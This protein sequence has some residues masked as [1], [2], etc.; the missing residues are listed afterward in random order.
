MLYQREDV[1]A[2]LGLS[3]RM[4]NRNRHPAVAEVH[5]GG[6]TLRWSDKSPMHLT[7][8]WLRDNCA[9]E[10]CRHPGNGQKLYEIVDLP[11]D[12]AA[13]EAMVAPDHKLCVLWSDG[14]RSEYAPDW[15]IDHDLLA[16]ARIDRRPA[17][18]LWGKEIGNDLL[19]GDWPALLADPAK[20][21][22]WLDRYHDLGFG[23][24]R[25]VPVKEGMV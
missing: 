19:I 4:P 24:L 17:Y 12:L 16:S 9:C 13:I 22:A 14:H 7:N 6:I 20:E 25:N 15:L 10:N 1:F 18:Q 11:D 23:L 21:L 5:D 8:F 3:A 2:A